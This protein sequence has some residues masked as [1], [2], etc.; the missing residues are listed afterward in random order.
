MH[1]A[2]GFIQLLSLGGTISQGSGGTLRPSSLIKM[3]RWLP[4]DIP[5]RGADATMPM[6]PDRIVEALNQ[7]GCIGVVVA[8]DLSGIES[9]IRELGSTSTPNV[10]PIIL[11]GAVIPPRSAGTDAPGNIADALR[12]ACDPATR[13][14]GVLVVVQGRIHAG[15][16]VRFGSIDRGQL[17]HSEPLGPIGLVTPQG[18]EI[19]RRPNME[20]QLAQEC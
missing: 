1:G 8:L 17:P 19:V 12:V 7:S 11:T 10:V 16:E 2:R 18:V 9:L 15:A 5:V 13:G 6:A 14:L 4:P 3:A 20:A